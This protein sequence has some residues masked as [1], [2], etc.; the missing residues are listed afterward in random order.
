M[1]DTYFLGSKRVIYIL[2]QSELFQMSVLEKILKLL[3]AVGAVLLVGGGVA[4]GIYFFLNSIPLDSDPTKAIETLRFYYSVTTAAV[5]SAIAII[6]LIILVFYNELNSK[7][8]G[9]KNDG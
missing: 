5:I 4:S 1:W 9:G 7:K 2:N 6:C 3:E 8:E